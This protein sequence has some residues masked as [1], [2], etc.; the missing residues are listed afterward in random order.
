VPSEG[1]AFNRTRQ[2]LLAG[3]LRTAATYWSRLVG[4]LLTGRE[5]FQQ[6]DGLWIVPSH[7]VHTL[8]MKFP[9][10]VIYLDASKRV[11]HIEKG[12]RPWRIAPVRRAAVSVLELPESTLAATG[13][14]L[15]DEI[16]IAVGD[17]A[18]ESVAE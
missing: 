13:T 7:G 16:E 18:R 6:G 12:L 8:G 11:I 3:R 4:L 17:K 2:V 15:G 14:S 1:Y 9:I 5:D 10:D